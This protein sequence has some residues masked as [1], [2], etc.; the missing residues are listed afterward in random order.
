MCLT[1]LRPVK[2]CRQKAGHGAVGRYEGNLTTYS[3][4]KKARSGVETCERLQDLKQR[5]RANS[6]VPTAECRVVVFNFSAFICRVSK[7][8][9]KSQPG[10]N[11]KMSADQMT[12]VLH[13]LVRCLLKCSRMPPS[14]SMKIC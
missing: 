5:I 14:D 11:V 4:L 10:P 3:A 2:I 12:F 7:T 8:F 13:C 6:S 9:H 1:A